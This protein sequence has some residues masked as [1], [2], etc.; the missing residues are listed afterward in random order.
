MFT[1]K[2][3]IVVP[4]YNME[5]YL[6]QC[7][8]SLVYQT[9]QGLQII[10]VNDGSTDQSLAIAQEYEQR[11]SNVHVISQKNQG[12]SAARNTGMEHATGEYIGFLDSD[13]W[14]CLDMFES[15]YDRA[16][17]DCA[18]LVI[19]DA[20]VVW[21]DLHEIGQFFDR[22]LWNELPDRCKIGPLRV[23]EEP[24]VLL[25]EPAAW[26]R[27]YKRSFL[28]RIGFQFSPGL[29]YEDVPSHFELLLAA[30]AVSLL[31][32][33][34]CFYRMGRPGKI[35]A[36]RDHTVFQVFDIFDLTQ[37]VL[38]AANADYLTWAMYLK[39]QMRFC[40]WLFLQV[41][42]NDR[43][44]FFARW[45]AQ[46][47]RVPLPA[48]KRHDQEF[49]GLR[50][51]FSMLCVRKGWFSWFKNLA[52]H[53]VTKTMKLY[54]ALR[55]WPRQEIREEL[56][57]HA[58]RLRGWAARI[59][60]MP[61]RQARSVMHSLSQDVASLQHR[62]SW[63]LSALHQTI[64]ELARNGSG[65]SASHNKNDACCIRGFELDGQSFVFTDEVG[66]N[67][68]WEMFER[69]RCNH[70]MHDSI[71]LRPGDIVFDIGAHV[72]VFSICIAKAHPEV[73]VFAVEPDKINYRNLLRNIK[74][75]RI[76]NVVPIRAAIT[77][78]GRTARIFT[79]LSCNSCVT[80]SE[81][82][83]ADYCD[84]R[85]ARVPSISLDE[86]FDKHSITCCRMMK[87]SSEGYETETLSSI[88]RP[89]PCIDY[90]CGDV[91][92]THVESSSLKV[93]SA[94]IAKRSFWRNKGASEVIATEGQISYSV[95][96]VVPVYNVEVYLP[97][98]IESLIAQTL[99]NMQ[100]ILVNDGSKDGSLEIIKGYARKHPQILCIDKPNGG[101]ASARNAG[102]RAAQGEYVGFVDGDDWV[103][104]TM[105]KKLYDKAAQSDAEIV[106][107]GLNKYYE[108]ENRCEP[109][110]ENWIAALLDRLGNR[111]DNAQE[112]ICVQP[113]IWRRIYRRSLL[114]DN[115]IE[116]P[117]DVRMFDDLPFQVMS[118]ASCRT[119]AVVNE[120]LYFYRLQ[121]NG[122]DVGAMDERIFVHFRLF[123][124]LND[125]IA[126]HNRHDLIP[127]LFRL[128]I[129]T[130]SW[131]LQQIGEQWKEAY[132]N[133][134]CDDLTNPLWRGCNHPSRQLDCFLA[135]NYAWYRS[136]EEGKMPVSL[137]VRLLARRAQ[138]IW[139]KAA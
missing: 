14:A 28:E 134:V 20:K 52:N 75:N 116:F 115:Q 97:Q 4:V 126:Q 102:L 128:Q 80:L 8:D 2:V 103:N 22:T 110:D 107:C 47:R 70:Y 69:M 48:F 40:T 55:Y 72:G 138:R 60:P 32:K 94:R 113:T 137:H 118:L 13:D 71:V 119:M 84:I 54:L 37:R 1:P 112:L 25:L 98:C 39:F 136:L 63:E 101:C 131:G 33:P 105:F 67:A 41:A 83:A 30:N 117:E 66:G 61:S 121:R 15:L 88:S 58:N 90:L 111:M 123:E 44:A 79:R 50:E 53:R 92:L 34:V 3:S 129:N 108:A 35:T 56:K 124:I 42:E 31:D 127:H 36:R 85:S 100:I 135:R 125:F 68:L 82:V 114:R 12:L 132:F 17:K 18:D 91:S 96:V 86:L 104:P 93:A 24:R 120:P 23:Q 57:K 95:S 19:A 51:R 38:Q 73:T 45:A 65:Q 5:K 27:L 43:G 29:I 7:L 99:S 9:L 49:F 21:E 78:H 74:F 11:Y 10:V 106:Q 139:R 6:P 64:A 122:Q 109:V 76:Q 77:A 89:Q 59:L 16:I 62:L 130:H 133:R 46:F 87:V 26:K 81:H